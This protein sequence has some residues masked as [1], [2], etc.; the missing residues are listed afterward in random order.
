MKLEHL[1]ISKEEI[2]NYLPHREPF[3]FVDEILEVVPG[4]SAIGIKRFNEDEPFFKG[5]FPNFPVL[6]GV[7]IIETCAQVSAFILLT[8]EKFRSSFGYLVNVENFKFIKKVHPGETLK[9]VASLA[10]VKFGIAKSKVEAY[11][12]DTLVATGTIA[13]KIIQS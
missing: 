1:K 4:E 13:I 7:I 5:H 11:I 3:L 9:V 6:P 10:N 8:L 2:K 12:N